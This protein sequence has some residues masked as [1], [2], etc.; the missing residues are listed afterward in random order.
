MSSNSD[1]ASSSGNDSSSSGN[2]SDAAWDLLLHSIAERETWLKSYGM[3]PYTHMLENNEYDT[4]KFDA[5]KAIEEEG[6]QFPVCKDAPGV[7]SD[8]FK[9]HLEQRKEYCLDLMGKSGAREQILCALETQC[10]ETVV[11]LALGSIFDC[12]INNTIWEHELGLILAIFHLVKEHAQRNKT[13]NPK[14]IF[15]DPIFCTADD[16]LLTDL[17][18]EVVQSPEAFTTKHTGDKTFVVAFNAP[19]VIAYYGI[20]PSSPAICLINKMEKSIEGALECKG[21]AGGI[22]D[23]TDVLGVVKAFMEGRES[24]DMHEVV[25]P[26]C[27]FVPSCKP[28]DV[29]ENMALYWKK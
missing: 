19:H 5:Y 3:M 12:D 13:P 10:I 16:R 27:P 7:L 1:S 14:L 17:E 24:V 26:I 4:E 9:Q 25:L 11:V 23:S 29:F 15:Q 8:E 28:S 21:H 6:K 18:G 20:Y 22:R 2:S